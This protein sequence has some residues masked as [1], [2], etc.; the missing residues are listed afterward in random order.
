MPGGVLPRNNI[1][2]AVEGLS[3]GLAT[4]L[5]VGGWDAHHDQ[6]VLRR[7]GRL[8][9]GLGKRELGIEAAGRQVM[10]LI[11][12]SSVSDPFIDQNHARADHAE[13]LHQSFAW[14]C[15]GL[16]GLLDQL[17]ALFPAELPREFAPECVDFGPVGHLVDLARRDV[18]ADQNGPLDLGQRVHAQGGEQLVGVRQIAAFDLR[19]EQVIQREYRVRLTAAEVRLE[20][21][22]RVALLVDQPLDRVGEQVA[23][24]FG[25]V[26]PAEELDGV[27]IL[28]CRD[29]L[30][31]LVEVR[32]EL[33]L[34]V[35]AGRDVVVGFHDFP[36]GRQ[37]RRRLTLGGLPGSLPGVRA[38]LLGDFEAH[39]L[40]LLLVQLEG[41]LAGADGREQTGHAVQGPVGIIG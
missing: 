40:H 38:G 31:D 9:Q 4:G 33:G 28:R 23:Q 8:G 15:R 6:R 26:G 34:L 21:D 12:L 13:E 36:P 11:K 7:R 24:A 19:V 22:D 16:V 5:D 30:P 29:A 32:G 41:L 35:V 39:D 18:L 17:V 20:G 10:L 25:Q 27:A 2:Q 1:F 14:V 37:A 3:S